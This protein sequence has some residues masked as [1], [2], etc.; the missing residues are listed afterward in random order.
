MIYTIDNLS[1]IVKLP[2]RGSGSRK[3]EWGVMWDKNLSWRF[4]ILPS[5]GVREFKMASVEKAIAELS[6]ILNGE[7]RI[8]DRLNELFNATTDR[9]VLHRVQNVVPRTERTWVALTRSPKVEDIHFVIEVVDAEFSVIENIITGQ[10]STVENPFLFQQDR[11]NVCHLAASVLS[12]HL[13][14]LDRLRLATE[15]LKKEISPMS[16]DPTAKMNQQVKGGADKTTKDQA[17]TE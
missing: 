9:H 7:I 3:S 4:T 2:N 17:P 5:E 16:Q 15:A 8:V 12:G 10:L 6:E 13:L 11:N 1:K 14:R